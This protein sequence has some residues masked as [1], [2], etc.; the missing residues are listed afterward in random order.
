[1]KSKSY[2]WVVLLVYILAGI[3]SQIMWITFSPILPIVEEIYNVGDAEVGLL[4]AVFPIVFIILALPI[5]YYVDKRGFRKAVLLGS[6]FFAVFGV[7]RVFATTFLLLLIFQTL[8]AVGQPFIFNSISKL[9]KSWF[10]AEEA[11]LATGLGSISLFIGTILGL[12]LTPVLTVTLG[13]EKMLLIYGVAAFIVLFLFFILGKEAETEVFEEEYRLKE[14]IDVL[15]NRNVSI[16]SIIAFIGVGI[17]TAYLTWVEPILEDHGLDV[18]TAGL[19]ASALLFGGIFGSI[20][21]PA[22][23]DRAG[24]RRPFLFV[25]FALS[26]VL[27]YIHTLTFGVIMLAVVLFILGFFFISALPLALDLSATSVGEKYAGTANSSLWLLSQLGSVL[28][29]VEFESM[30]RGMNWD[31][32]LMLSAA[33]LG[34]SFLL[35]IFLR[36]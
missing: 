31:S 20:L 3:I 8:A 32:T 16:L 9:V 15:K 25:C 4:S 2:R 10:P 35:T 27:F 17:F 30:A 18:E 26:A 22:L 34:L 24:K 21:I 11:G 6:A 28:L 33:L 36:E 13:F 14:Y 12:S 7:L 5:G 23:S 29:I 1:M 19:T